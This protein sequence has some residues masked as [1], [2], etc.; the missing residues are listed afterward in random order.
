M[1]REWED[2]FRAWSKAPGTT[3]QGKCE[4]AESQ[5]RR[6]IRASSALPARTIEVFSQGS[7]RN[8]TNVRADSDVD[9]CVLCT[10]VCFY[11]LL[12]G[13]TLDETGLQDA[14]YPYAD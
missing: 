10:D 9:I 12:E 8:R 7:Y 6:A 13:V 3:E 11:L 1:A 14:S 4:S 2:A 5:V